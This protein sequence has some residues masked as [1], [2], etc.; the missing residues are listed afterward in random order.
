MKATSGEIT[1]WPD[2]HGFVVA[3]KLHCLVGPMHLG[4]LAPAERSKDA[5]AERRGQKEVVRAESPRLE[6][7]KGPKSKSGGLRLAGSG[8]KLEDK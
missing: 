1:A 5:D 8:P 4:V 7:Q 2:S 3:R 6:G